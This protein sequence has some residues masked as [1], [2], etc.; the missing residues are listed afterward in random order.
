MDYRDY[1]NNVASPQPPPLTG[2]ITISKHSG[3]GIASFVMS[4]FVGLTMF[5]CFMVAGIMQMQAERQ[6]QSSV[7]ESSPIAII[8]GL[9]ILADILLCLVSFILGIAALFQT[10]RKKVF[11]VLGIVF[12][13]L[14]GIGTVGMI[15]LG[16]I[17]E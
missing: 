10:E 6:G 12:S 9:F 13:V 3:L 4:I 15:I 5:L 8:I 11:A 7:D 14:I 1:N 16:L 17:M 2:E